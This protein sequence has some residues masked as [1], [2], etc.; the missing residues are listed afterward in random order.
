MADPLAHCIPNQSGNHRDADAS[1]LL[2]WLDKSCVTGGS[3]GAQTS[4]EGV[5][6]KTLFASTS[7]CTL[8]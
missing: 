6:V 1:A 3:H 7:Q 4:R 5:S 8:L 2:E